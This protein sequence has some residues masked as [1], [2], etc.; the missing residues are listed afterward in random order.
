MNHQDKLRN[1]LRVNERRRDQGARIPFTINIIIAENEFTGKAIQWALS[2][3]FD[4]TVAV[5][6]RE[7]T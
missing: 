7:N 3:I 1:F 6:F 4:C 5:F 2:T